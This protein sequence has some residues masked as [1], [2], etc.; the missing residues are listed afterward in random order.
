MY[1]IESDIADMKNSV[2]RAIVVYYTEYSSIE[3]IG[4]RS[5]N[6]EKLCT[7]VPYIIIQLLERNMHIEAMSIKTRIA[8]AIAKFGVRLKNRFGRARERRP[9][10]GKR[11]RGA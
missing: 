6:Q 10:L 3:L 1:S 9:K 8:L 11:A 5:N 2:S 4:S 7:I